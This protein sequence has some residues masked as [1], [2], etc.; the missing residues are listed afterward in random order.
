MNCHVSR[1][2]PLT[3][4]I[5]RLVNYERRIR[6]EC[7]ISSGTFALTLTEDHTSLPQVLFYFLP[8]NRWLRQAAGIINDQW[9]AVRLRN[10]RHITNSGNKGN[11]SYTITS[12]KQKSGCSFSQH[13]LMT[14]WKVDFFFFFKNSQGPPAVEDAGFET[15]L[16]NPALSSL[17][18]QLTIP[19]Y[20]F[21][22]RTFLKES[23]TPIFLTA[24]LSSAT[25]YP[26][27]HW[28]RSESR[29]ERPA[30]DQTDALNHTRT[31]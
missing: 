5:Y 9:W 11:T 3:L 26:R 22:K 27:I 19:W 30:V 1:S 31:V 13:I 20:P 17:G 14:C 15:A 24:V 10:E 8:L 16:W 7:E 23:D 28:I 12:K 2:V 6:T 25:V 21:E 18:S 4:N 29:V